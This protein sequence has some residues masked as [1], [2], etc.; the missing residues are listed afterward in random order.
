MTFLCFT[1]PCI[2]IAYQLNEKLDDNNILA[3]TPSLSNRL[4]F[5]SCDFLVCRSAH[6]FVA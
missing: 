2:K 1:C 6:W 4:N 5:V 3:P